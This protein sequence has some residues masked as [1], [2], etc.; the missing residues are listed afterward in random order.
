M[1]VIQGTANSVV[2]IYPADR[3]TWT[4]TRTQTATATGSV[5]NV[6]INN[7]EFY[8]GNAGAIGLTDA[9]LGVIGKSGK[10]SPLTT[11]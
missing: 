4:E 10:F 11:R 1:L 5:E 9:T 7:V 3:C 6:V 2:G 8:P